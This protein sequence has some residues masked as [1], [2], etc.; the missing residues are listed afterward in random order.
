MRKDVRESVGLR[1]TSE[2]F[3]T[4]SIN[5]MISITRSQSGPSLMNKLSDW[6]KQQCDEIIR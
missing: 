1:F 6:V 4:E 3:T 2:M 5:A